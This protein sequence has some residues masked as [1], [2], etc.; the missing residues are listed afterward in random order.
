MG[1]TI[2]KWFDCMYLFMTEYIFPAGQ[3]EFV[4]NFFFIMNQ[5]RKVVSKLGLL[6]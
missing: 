3:S 5:E 4:K 6:C 1:L 2:Y